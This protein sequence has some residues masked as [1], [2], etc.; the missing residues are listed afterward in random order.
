VLTGGRGRALRDSFCPTPPE[1]PRPRS[2]ARH[3]PHTAG[4]AR[5]AGH[6]PARADGG[7]L[8]HGELRSSDPASLPMPRTRAQQGE[9]VEDGWAEL[10]D[11]LVEK[12]LEQ[13]QAAQ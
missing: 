7:T 5:G 13:L 11:D 6:S 1:L 2:E 10:P 12:V 3:T 9:T 8:T 4:A